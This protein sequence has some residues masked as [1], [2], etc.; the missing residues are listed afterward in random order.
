MNN[1]DFLYETIPR[2]QIVINPYS[3]YQVVEHSFDVVSSWQEEV[4]ITIE[5]SIRL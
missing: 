5:K 2:I 4:A 3:I 1:I